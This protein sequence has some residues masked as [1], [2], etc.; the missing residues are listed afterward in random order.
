MLHDVNEKKDQN[1]VKI[2]HSKNG[3]AILLLSYLK[4]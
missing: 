3:G 4:K 2:D 1:K